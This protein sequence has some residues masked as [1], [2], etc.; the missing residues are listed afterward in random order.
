MFGSGFLTKF[1]KCV[2]VYNFLKIC[3]MMAFQLG[4]QTLADQARN[5]PCA[6]L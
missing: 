3:L 4:L 5:V 1:Q 2:C 6:V